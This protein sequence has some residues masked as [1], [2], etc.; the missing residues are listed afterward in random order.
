MIGIAKVAEEEGRNEFGLPVTAN[1]P[2][3]RGNFH[4]AVDNSVNKA[5][6]W[7][8]F[9]WGLAF[10]AIGM[11]VVILAAAPAYIDA[12]VA[13][14]VAPAMATANT[15][16][17]HARVALDKVEQTQVQLGAKGLVQPSTH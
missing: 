8:A 1:A 16:R 5:L 3:N 14:G 11:I 2:S 6:P 4:Q 7:V 13:A 10:F 15:A 12:K 17:E 9:S